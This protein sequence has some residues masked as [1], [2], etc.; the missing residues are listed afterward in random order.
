MI[1][2]D[3]EKNT[4]NPTFA[5]VGDGTMDFVG[6][7]ETMRESGTKYFLVEQDNAAELPDTLE[8]VR[9]SANYLKTL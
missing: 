8:Q 6:L 1:V 7:I 3:A 4:F 2:H 5:P 9:R